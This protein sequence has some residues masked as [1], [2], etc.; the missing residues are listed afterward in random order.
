MKKTYLLLL[1]LGG[2]LFSSCSE[3][4]RIEGFDSS[5]WINDKNACNGTRAEMQRD[6][7]AIRKELYGKE[8]KEIR[9]I[10]GKPD[11]EQLMSRG[12]RMFYYYLEAGSQCQEN[13]K[14]STA[15]KAEIRFNSLNK[16]SEITY[17]RPLANT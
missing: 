4:A 12:Q 1:L 9:D 17:T 16:V 8:E 3:P 2:L 7:D 11:G 15:N 6:F 13:N 10:L 14:L 5:T